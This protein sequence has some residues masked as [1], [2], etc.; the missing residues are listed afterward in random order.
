MIYDRQG[1]A[2]STLSPE[3]VDWAFV[4][5]A[6]HLH[7]SGILPGL[8]LS[9]RDTTERAI[10]EARQGELSV[11]FDVNYRSQLWSTEE[12]GRELGRLIRGVDVLFVSLSEAR[13]LYGIRE[14]PERTAEELAARF[15]SRVVVVS[16]GA[17]GCAVHEENLGTVRNQAYRSV[18]L[19]RFGAG[20]AF[21]AGFL[22]GYLNGDLGL[23][24]KYGSAM[25]ALKLGI[26]DVNFPMVTKAEIEDL[27][28][29]EEKAVT[30]QSDME[31]GVYR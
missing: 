5:K 14:S 7:L 16:L 1:S 8:S 15:G 20:D 9:C 30:D 29:R 13:E 27:I 11:S 4:R 24:I 19:N 21:V 6:H 2:A 18:V 17:E 23:G 25:A 28:E 22:Y 31:S 3:E 26:T 12:A 10:A